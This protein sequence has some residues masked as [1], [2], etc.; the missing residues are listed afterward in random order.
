MSAAL[1]ATT[2]KRR[3]EQTREKLLASALD[4]FARNGYERATVDQIVREAGFSKGAFYVHF[5]SKEDLFFAMLEARLTALQDV[6]R[7]TLD[8]TQSVAENERRILGTLFA[9]DRKESKWRA[10]FL[11][12]AAHAARNE[13]VGEKLRDL[14]QRWHTFTVEMLE[15]G[16]QAGTVR[17]DIDVNFMASVIVALIEGSLT[18]MRLAPDYMRLDKRLD[19]L[20]ELLGAWLEP[21]TP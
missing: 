21:P 4:V 7:Q 20:S 2:K 14:Y 11:E 9:Q 5:G 19:Q 13:R 6:L 3:R 15:T 1:L 16:R 17:T 18:Q 10:L 12:F 8:T